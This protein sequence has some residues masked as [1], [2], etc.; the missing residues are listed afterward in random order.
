MSK[1]DAMKPE[2]PE[3]A[4]GGQLSRSRQHVMTAIVAVMLCGCQPIVLDPKGPV[5]AGENLILYNAFAIMLVIVV[6]TILGTLA[7]AWWFR[8]SNGRAKHLPDLVYSGRVELVTWAIPTLV[9]LLLGGVI[10]IGSHELDPALPLRSSAKP[11]EVEVV[12]L[13]WKW[14]F[15]YPDEGVASVNELVVPAGVPVHFKLTSASVMS[16]F[17]VPQLGSMIYTMNGMTTQLNL[18]ADQPGDFHGMSSHFNGDGFP[19]MYFT[20]HAVSS[21]DYGAWIAKTR[22]AGPVLD[23]AAYRGLSQQSMNVKPVTYRAAEAGL[24]HDIVVQ[25]LPP[26][27][28]PSSSSSA[29]AATN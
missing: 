16:A 11:V 13:D 9:I 21:P 24:F 10:W 27:P 2:G 18:M 19:G 22:T 5:G 26:G 15:I 1:G 14:L 12:S 6:P 4:R 29:S 3:A 17:F 28:G 8:S 23:A 20:V 7:I 25:K